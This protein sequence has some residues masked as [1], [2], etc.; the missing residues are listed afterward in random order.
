[1]IY[2][3][4]EFGVFFEIPMSSPCYQI[5]RGVNPLLQLVFTF[6]QMYFIFMNARVCMILFIS[7]VIWILKTEGWKYWVHESRKWSEIRPVMILKKS[8]AV[9]F[10]HSDLSCAKLSS[11]IYLSC[12]VFIFKVDKILH[13]YK[14]DGTLLIE[15]W[16]WYPRNKFILK[17]TRWGILPQ[18]PFENWCLTL[19]YLSFNLLI[20]YL[21]GWNI[22]AIEDFYQFIL[23]IFDNTNKNLYF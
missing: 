10:Y 6:M 23:H 21:L 14:N 4:L 17:H 19:D 11:P 16:K 1:M 5:L 18:N 7:F 22:S 12:L 15:K 13:S 3:G 9:I 2:N 20:E 8:S